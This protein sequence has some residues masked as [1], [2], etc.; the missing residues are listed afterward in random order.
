[1]VLL[2]DAAA[3]CVHHER[4]VLRGAAEGKKIF[5]QLLTDND[6]TL[7]CVCL[8]S[9]HRRLLDSYVCSYHLYKDNDLTPVCV[10]IIYTQK[11]A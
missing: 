2:I 1:M 4:K 10:L 8:S 7:M 3:V 6:L 5:S 11:M 9:I